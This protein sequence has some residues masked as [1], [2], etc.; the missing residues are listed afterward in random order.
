MMKEDTMNIWR[1]SSILVVALLIGLAGCSQ[2]SG[3]EQVLI[4][5]LRAQGATVAHTND[6]G[7][8]PLT[9]TEE[10]L[11]V[12]GEVVEVYSYDSLQQANAEAVGISADGLK[13]VVGTAGDQTT[14]TALTTQFSPHF[15]KKGRLIVFYNGGKS[16][17]ANLLQ[18]VLGPQIAGT[19]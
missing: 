2:G 4:T 7:E 17:V 19:S 10:S 1:W 15:Y 16:A 9:G 13:V 14:L 6:E 12:N 5:Q 8:L 18:V 11:K 3:E